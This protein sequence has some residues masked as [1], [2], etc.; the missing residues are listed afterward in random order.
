M[1]CGKIDVIFIMVNWIKARFGA[2]LIFV[3]V[4][5]KTIPK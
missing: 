2:G 4:S 5:R 3:E 1:N